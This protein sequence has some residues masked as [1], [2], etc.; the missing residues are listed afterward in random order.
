MKRDILEVVQIMLPETLR[1][2]NCYYCNLS[3]IL[4]LLYKLDMLKLYLTLVCIIFFSF[5]SPISK[6][7][8]DHDRLI[9][10]IQEE[11]NFRMQEYPMFATSCG[12]YQYNDQLPVMTVEAEHRRAEFW[13]DILNRLAEV[14]RSSLSQQD[15]IN[16]DFFQFILED[17]VAGIENE[18]YLVPIHGDEGFH[19]NFL[20][21]ADE[22]PFRNEK[23]Y[24]NYISRL[25]GYLE[26]TK[27]HINLMKEG[28]E[29]GITLPKVVL[30]NYEVTIDPHIVDDP[31][32]SYF[33][34]PFNKMPST[35]PKKVQ[36]ILK[37]RAI[38]A[39]EK[40]I[41]PG[42]LAFREFLVNVYRPNATEAIAVSERPNGKAYYDQRVKF[43]TS[44]SMTSQDVF[45]LG[46]QEVS[47]IQ[48]EMEAIIDSLHFGG[49][50]E[51]FLHFLRTD[52][53]FYA[54]TPE[55]LL[56]EAAFIAK[57]IDGKL[58]Q[59][60]KTLP[61]LPYG[62]EPV[63]DAIAPKYTAGRY[64][65]GSIEN[66]QAG[67]Y[68]VNTYKLESRPLYVLP[69]LTL[70]EAVPGHHLQIALAQEME[71]MPEFRRHTYLSAHGEGWALYAEWLGKELN[72]YKN[73]YEHFG[74]LTY[75]MWRACR[76]VVDVG[77]HAK[78]WTRD[79]AV[80]FMASHT[81]LS[82]HEINT[83]IDRYIGWPG[84]AI[85]YKV[86]ELKIKEL[87]KNAEDKLGDQFD[88]RE[89]HE[90]VLSS[91]S[92]PLFILEDLVDSYIY[93]NMH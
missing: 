65:P 67:K 17:L 31:S 66:H 86:G 57:E 6:Q 4:S 63:P 82:L 80:D 74:R 81:A 10:L 7:K 8:N 13:R 55:G 72:V 35:I 44:L 21:M 88:V 78:G 34:R 25:E 23:D 90:V 43:F 59:L 16:Y 60:F 87:R 68:W 85:S 70:H 73:L 33:F 48:S 9:K 71:R 84:Q 56:K 77:I 27:Q 12:V 26:Y 15:I 62:V 91:G 45:E 29:K 64:V 2:F 76:L 58:P 37:T 40:S 93:E 28:L 53:Q 79:Q 89:F 75:E 50:F 38:G 52:E 39:I 1:K 49:S 22:M 30:Q 19:I 24:Q 36:A 14:D 61:R 3:I 41:V 54:Q 11:W 5:V 46:Q 51:D 69:A 20:Y 83:E 47:R 42:F 18:A 92:V 32:Q